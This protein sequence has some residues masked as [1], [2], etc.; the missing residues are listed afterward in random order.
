MYRPTPRSRAARA[1]AGLAGAA[2]GA[3]AL[4]GL[5]GPATAADDSAPVQPYLADQL[6]SLAGGELTHV[7]VHGTDIA[8]ARAAVDATGMRLVTTFDQVGVAVAEAS[9]DQIEAA[10]TQSG[11]TYLEGNTPIEYTLETSN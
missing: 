1:L 8:A 5:A 3:S 7:M 2:L 9:A 4:A 6:G 10:R 11:V